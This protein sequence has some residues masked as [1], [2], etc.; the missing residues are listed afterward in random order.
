MSK[1][2]KVIYRHIPAMERIS[3][4]ETISKEIISIYL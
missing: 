4:M 1:S 2:K 3:G